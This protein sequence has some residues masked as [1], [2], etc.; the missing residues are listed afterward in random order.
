MKLISTTE[1]KNCHAPMETYCFLS[2]NLFSSSLLQGSKVLFIHSFNHALI[3]SLIHS[4]IHSFNHAL[5]HSFIQSSTHSFI[6][7]FIQSR[8][9]SLIHPLIH[10]LIHSVLSHE[11]SIAP[12]TTSSPQ[13]AIWCFLFQFPVSSRFLK[14]KR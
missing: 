8:T 11:R 12:S 4:F 9:H 6:H 7:S 13:R 5:I 10:S 14:V 1:H 3:H 2:N